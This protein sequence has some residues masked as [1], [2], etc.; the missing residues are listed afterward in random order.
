MVLA[1]RQFFSK[2]GFDKSDERSAS[3]GR[4]P[5]RPSGL[6][7]TCPAGLGCV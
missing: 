1:K 3:S 6:F 5:M 2:M 4:G 7:K